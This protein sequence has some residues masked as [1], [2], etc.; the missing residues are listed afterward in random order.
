MPYILHML[1]TLFLVQLVSVNS[2]ATIR[3]NYVKRIKHFFS[4]IIGLIV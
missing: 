3:Y 1:N 2:F 4:Q